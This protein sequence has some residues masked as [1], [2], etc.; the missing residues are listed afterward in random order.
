MSAAVSPASTPADRQTAPVSAAVSPASAPGR[1]LSGVVPGPLPDAIRALEQRAPLPA[2]LRSRR[3]NVPAALGRW[4]ASRREALRRTASA[5]RPTDGQ[6][7]AAA[8]AAAGAA[9]RG[10]SFKAADRLQQRRLPDPQSIS[11]GADVAMRIAQV[12]GV[13]R[14]GV[15]ARKLLPRP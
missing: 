13:S 1:R 7:A 2:P 3:P 5:R 15:V 4:T 11:V 10:A 8:A 9:R 14:V 12:S 6:P